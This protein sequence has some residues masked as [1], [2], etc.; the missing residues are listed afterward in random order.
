W[1][2]FS[3]LTG[4]YKKAIGLV[5]IHLVITAVRNIAEPK[6]IGDKVGVHPLL[7]L[8]AVF[9]GLKIFGVAGI[10]LLPVTVVIIK[11]LIP[12]NIGQN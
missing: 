9:L 1:A 12:E 6:I 10:I 7:M 8:A 4:D 11:S 5:V 2:V 3:I